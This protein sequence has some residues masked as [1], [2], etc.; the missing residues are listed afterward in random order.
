MSAADIIKQVA[1]SHGLAPSDIK[2]HRRCRPVAWARQETMARLYE[3]G[4]SLGTIARLLG[5]LHHTTVMH[6]KR[7]HYER[8]GADQ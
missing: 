7:R 6:G 4:L 8:A 1:Q 5:G 3:Y 2:G